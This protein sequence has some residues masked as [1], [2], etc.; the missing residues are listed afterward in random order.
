VP[1][2]EGAGPPFDLAAGTVGSV[3][4]AT[5]L[6]VS[7]QFGLGKQFSGGGCYSNFGNGRYSIQAFSAACLLMVPIA[8][9][10]NSV[11]MG[12]GGSGIELRILNGKINLL[13]SGVAQVG[14]S[15]T[16]WANNIFYHAGVSYDGT[17]ANFYLNGVADGTASSAQTFSNGDLVV[18]ASGAGEYLDNGSILV[19]A[20][21]WDRVLG[22]AEFQ[23]IAQAPYSFFATPR[24]ALFSGPLA[25]A[26][27]ISLA[28]SSGQPGQT[29]TVTVTGTGT[30]FAGGTTA[31]S[32]SGTGVSVGTIAV[33]SATSLTV[34]L[35]IASG[36]T[37]GARTLTVTTGA[38][39]PTTTFTVIAPLQRGNIDY[40][41]I[42]STARQGAGAMFQM[43]GGGTVTAGHGLVYD[44]G[45]NAIDSGVSVSSS[46]LSV[47][48]GLVGLVNVSPVLVNGHAIS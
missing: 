45:G 11:W 23:R 48:G 22:P 14:S 4:T 43:F 15:T 46:N 29:V 32:V 47:N 37:L 42:R 30:H 13:K 38:E 9:T 34:A 19:Y 35:T 31:V 5:P 36:A 16:T 24:R 33:S 17:N 21:M 10:A 44:T 41:Q 20:Y 6:A 39:A 1:L 40:D 28:P 12:F 2:N 8:T 7:T 27:S 18:G 25:A 26:A 3:V